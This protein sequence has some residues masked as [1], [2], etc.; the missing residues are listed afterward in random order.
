MVEAHHAAVVDVVDSVAVTGEDEV[1]LEVDS[2]LAVR[3]AADGEVADLAE[4][5]EVGV[6]VGTAGA[7]GEGIKCRV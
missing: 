4:V 5:G 1:V 3:Q 6:M 2:L 7:G